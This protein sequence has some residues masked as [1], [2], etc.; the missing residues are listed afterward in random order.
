MAEDIVRVLRI[1]EYTGTRSAVESL[2]ATSIHGEKVVCKGGVTIR[3]TTLGTYPEIMERAEPEKDLRPGGIMF[4]KPGKS[5]G[6][7]G[8]CHEG[9][10]SEY[11]EILEADIS[12]RT[13]G[14]CRYAHNGTILRTHA[15]DCA[16]HNS[17][18]F[19]LNF[20]DCEANVP[21]PVLF[22]QG[23]RE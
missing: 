19:T 11:P 13:P 20:C 14:T 15:S 16:I 5:L 2:V 8:P 17:V 23:S 1:I 18:T 9:V 10:E 21:K 3:A 12:P 6:T 4:V 22:D 7:R